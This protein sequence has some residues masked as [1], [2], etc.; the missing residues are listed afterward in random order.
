MWKCL[1]KLVCT[2]E[3]RSVF[4]QVAK[5]KAAG[6]PDS[7]V[8]SVAETLLKGEEVKTVKEEE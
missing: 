8:G 1:T 5:F 7:V 6:I 4:G 3:G 2:H